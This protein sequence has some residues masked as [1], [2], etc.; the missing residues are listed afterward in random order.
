MVLFVQTMSAACSAYHRESNIEQWCFYLLSQS[1]PLPFGWL[2][3]RLYCKALNYSVPAQIERKR[4][5]KEGRDIIFDSSLYFSPL[6]SHC[7]S[8]QTVFTRINPGALLPALC[9][10][11]LYCGVT[12]LDTSVKFALQLYIIN[13][14]KVC[15]IHMWWTVRSITS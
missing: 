3:H 10:F 2:Y 9:F 12:L 6:P 13:S 7:T 15:L 11:L 4:V 14:C 1:E 8:V 5:G